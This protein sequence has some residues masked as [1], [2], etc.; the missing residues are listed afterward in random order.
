MRS[1]A[2]RGAGFGGLCEA[3]WRA[4]ALAFGLALA[5]CG[6]GGGAIITPG[7]PEPPAVDCVA[8]PSD[9]GEARIGVAAVSDGDFLSYAVEVVSIKLQREGGGSVEALPVR[10]RVDFAALADTT[11]LIASAAIPNGTYVGAKIRLDYAEAE[12]TVE[13]EGVPR[14]AAVV[15]SA[16]DSL[17]IV[18]LE[19][20]F[21]D[22]DPMVVA[23]DA[24][25]F[26]QL[27]LDLDATQVIN[28]LPDPAV[29]TADLAFVGAVEPVEERPVAVIG[30][31]V[32]VDGAGGSYVAEL[33]PFSEEDE[34]KRNGDVTVLTTADTRFE[35]D[36]EPLEEADALAA[37]ADLGPDARTAAT[38]VYDVDA[39]TFTA[40]SVLAGDSVPGAT[41]DT[42][43]GNVVS[44]TG[45][46]LIVRGGSVIRTDGT[47][48]YA[49]GD[50]RVQV[51]ANT[52]VRKDG[53]DTVFDRGAISVGQ[54][55]S[56][57]GDTTSSDVNPV[58]DARGARVQ[59]HPTHLSGF[60]ASLAGGELRMD[61][62]T[63]DGRNARFFDFTNTGGTSLTDADPADYRLDS[64]DLALDDFE[65]DDPIR[66]SGFVTPFLEAPP[67]FTATSLAD[68]EALEAVLGI[69]WGTTGT[70]TP[71]AAQGQTGFTIDGGNT[72]LGL[73]RFISVGARREDITTLGASMRVEPAEDG[74]L[75]FAISRENEVQV[76]RDFGDFATKMSD[77]L[78]GGWRMRSL[79][80]RGD[81]DEDTTTLAARYVTVS[82]V[83]P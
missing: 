68:V 20:T 12:V 53:D 69:G 21:D 63:I 47:V 76:F 18:D 15:D 46:D 75:L 14:A 79:T 7:D 32:S 41:F 16:G 23:T 26:V 55:I 49:L 29:V 67:D 56:A 50:V 51:D 34:D 44:R 40:D 57:F 8:T 39:Q 42:V 61:L 52:V 78:G 45:T 2:Q 38:G 27:A 35:V 3:A 33:R 36:G 25:A 11:D 17:G 71:F 37:I 70:G 60:V 24:P 30:P 74:A 31:L 13:T 59:L 28:P 54:R 9:C 48:V 81:F 73:R 66:A 80:A 83:R 5:G 6:D 77:L 64:G 10:Q 22:A 58:L 4:G 62:A 1:G 72:A 19:V 43:V 65:L 82:F